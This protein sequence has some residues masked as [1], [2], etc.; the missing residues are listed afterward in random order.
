MQTPHQYHVYGMYAGGDWRVLYYPG[1]L[2]R[3]ALGSSSLQC[4]IMC[5][6]LFE[7]DYEVK[8]SRWMLTSK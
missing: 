3:D 7:F 5:F 8:G 4:D 2:N 1:M 6:S